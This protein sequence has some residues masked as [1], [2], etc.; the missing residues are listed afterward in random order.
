MDARIDQ[1]QMGMDS[2]SG[3]A[4]TNARAA[5]IEELVAQRKQMRECM[6]FQGSEMANGSSHDH[7]AHSGHVTGG[8]KHSRRERCN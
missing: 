4:K 5:L 1:M 7:T 6:A 3:D 8:M 2:A